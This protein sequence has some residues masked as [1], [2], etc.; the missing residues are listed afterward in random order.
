MPNINVKR[1]L[2]NVEKE[3]TKVLEAVVYHSGVPAKDAFLVDRMA[4]GI[5]ELATAVA[6]AAREAAGNSSADSVLKNVRKALGYNVRKA[7]E[8]THP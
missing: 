1:R 6:A 3:M 5:A 4:T 8:Y 7:L 2:E